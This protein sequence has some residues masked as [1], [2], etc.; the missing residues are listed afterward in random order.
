[1]TTIKGQNLR[2]FVEDDQAF[3]A[4]TSCTVHIQME[5]SE[6]STKD[7]ES[8]WQE[9]EVVGM[10][11]DCQVDGL[12]VEKPQGDGSAVY[13]QDIQSLME[14]RIPITVFFAT[15]D[16]AKNREIDGLLLTGNAI[17]TDFQLTT[18]N[19]QNSVYSVKLQSVGELKIQFPYVN[20]SFELPV[21]VKDLTTA[22]YLLLTTTMTQQEIIDSLVIT[23]SADNQMSLSGASATTILVKKS[24]TVLFQMTFDESNLKKLNL[25]GI[26]SSSTTQIVDIKIVNA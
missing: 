25:S 1:M 24:S 22:D 4:A 15:S 2:L 12:V 26:N 8:D 23:D 17:I 9:N 14:A 10:S 7:S 5:V 20:P 21:V 16:G 6:S 18:Q 3:A 19:R 13:V 11:W